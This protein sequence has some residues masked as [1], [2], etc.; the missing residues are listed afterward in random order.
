MSRLR[1]TIGA[2]LGLSAAVGI[3]L[4]GAVV[5]AQ[6]MVGSSVQ[7]SEAL[8]RNQQA[9]E[10]LSL[11]SNIV[12]RRM[13]A[14]TKDIRL[15]LDDAQVDK[16]AEAVTA[17]MAEAE[18]LL[19]DAA[20]RAALPAN[21]QRLEKIGDLVAAYGQSTLDIAAV[22]KEEIA[23]DAAR[24]T[25]SAQWGGLADK[26]S[27]VLE[28]SSEPEKMQRV[29]YGIE[30]DYQQIRANSWRYLVTQDAELIRSIA[31]SNERATAAFATVRAS[32]GGIP[33]I[34]EPVDQLA[35]AFASYVKT[36]Q[37]VLAL[38][39]RVDEIVEK[40]SL[41][42]ATEAITLVREAIT[43][44]D[45]R[46]AE[47]EAA[48]DATAAFGN[49]V[50]YG[51][52]GLLILVLVASA[53]YA[54]WG[55]ARPLRAMTEAMGLIGRG[56][57]ATTIPSATRGDELGEQA[58]VLGVFRDGLAEAK[59]LREETA[60]AEI[61]AAAKRKADMLA[62]A[63]QFEAAVG[64]IVEMVSS[65]A[66]ELQAAAQSLTATSEETAA[67]AAAV[68]AAAE[69]AATNVQT[70][71]AAVEELAASASEIGQ[72]VS[73]ST[74]VASRAVG[75]A[76][77]T[78]TR[79]SSLRA[80]ADKIGA[81]VGLIGDIAAQTNLLALNATIESARAGEAGKGFAV[82]AQE[83]KSLAE[84]TS[85][86]TAEIS[87]QIGG[88]QGSTE[89]AV[90]AISSVGRTIGDI[91]GIAAAIVAAVEE[92]GATTAA[93][94]RNVQ[95]AAQGT[96]EVTTNIAAVL[97]AAEVSSSAATQVL[98]SASELARQSET[99]RGEVRKFVDHVRAA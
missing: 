20:D 2:K 40:Q 29:F 97:Q 43:A 48:A 61:E 69:E 90:I 98:S 78:N 35:Q 41:P 74:I 16:F 86:A 93:V 91:N 32:V 56:E 53:A 82:V 51:M 15:T 42:L 19:G 88:M 73:Q 13:Q 99:L 45:G 81:I 47:G 71:A 57:L 5:V 34:A 55:I 92:Q 54:I 39:D 38:N 26:A 77:E 64:K 89:D 46:V 80:D 59:R 50:I 87:A 21:K 31:E 12:L 63:E 76:G 14:T 18:K 72:Q 1:L 25:I 7:E 94:A 33:A 37:A 9:I 8:V 79:M 58:K 30:R 27:A 75:E 3:L 23:G 84:Q 6:V 36:S 11:Q 52:V 22:R 44:A 10:S 49:T 68:A 17:D 60:R 65:A 4:A 96:N 28:A 67:Q 85:K 95:Q 24:N 83:V 66:T 62:L 70:V